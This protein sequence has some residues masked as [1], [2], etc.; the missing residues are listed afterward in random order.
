[1]PRKKDETKKESSIVDEKEK[2]LS[3]E[4]SNAEAYTEPIMESGN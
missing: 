1:M 2:D 4:I 3:T